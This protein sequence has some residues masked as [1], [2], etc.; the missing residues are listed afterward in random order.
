[1]ARGDEAPVRVREPSNLE[2]AVA[3][4][5]VLALGAF[6]VLVVILLTPLSEV[7][8]QFVRSLT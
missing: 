7:V 3:V 8:A 2:F 4:G 1:M 5:V 6:L